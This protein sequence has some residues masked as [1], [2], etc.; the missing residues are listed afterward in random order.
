MAAGELGR[1]EDDYVSFSMKEQ[2]DRSARAQDLGHKNFYMEAKKS[3]CQ[4]VDPSVQNM[5]PSAQTFF[6]L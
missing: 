5:Q 6:L 2:D 4:Y 1:A 3:E